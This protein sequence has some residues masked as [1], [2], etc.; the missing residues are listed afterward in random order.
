MEN[1]GKF[2]NG[3]I[4]VGNMLTWNKLAGAGELMGCKGSCGEYCCGCYNAEN[5]MKSDCY[6]F[7]SYNLYGESVIQS[8]IN[9]TEAMREDLEGTFKRLDEN[10]SR[11]HKVKPIRI[12]ASGEFESVE[13]IVGW[14]KLAKKHEKFP[15]YVY[16]KAFPLMEEALKEME[17]EGYPTNFFINVSIWHE[18]GIDFYK[19]YS[20]LPFIRAFAYDDGYDYESHGLK[21]PTYCPAYR[22]E[23]KV[24]KDGSI[25]ERVVLKH[26]LTCDKCK[27]CFSNNNKVV[28]CLS[29]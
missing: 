23:V 6:V 26:D 19:K 13:E 7:K 20:H 11:R 14:M 17:G 4:K 25:S 10:L 24:R 15:F 18:S 3:N 1:K 21:I 2:T 8:H 5:P 16:S 28:G 9:N 29:H 27:L 12:H 22:K